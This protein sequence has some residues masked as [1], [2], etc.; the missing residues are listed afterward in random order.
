VTSEGEIDAVI[1]EA[2]TALGRSGPLAG[3]EARV[4]NRPGVYAIYGDAT[5]WTEL[6]LGEPSDPRPLYIGKAEG[7]NVRPSARLCS[8]Y[9]ARSSAQALRPCV[10]A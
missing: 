1:I 8:Y 6:G 3:A 10:A 9:D 4:P 2:R 5:T 7:P